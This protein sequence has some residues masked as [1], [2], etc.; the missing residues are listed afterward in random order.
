MKVAPA[1]NVLLDTRPQIFVRSIHLSHGDR[2]PLLHVACRARGA[3]LGCSP[4]GPQHE[5]P[6]T[7]ERLLVR[8]ATDWRPPETAQGHSRQRRQRP[9]AR[10]RSRAQRHRNEARHR[11]PGKQ[12][13]EGLCERFLATSDRRSAQN[14]DAPATIAG[15]PNLLVSRSVRTCSAGTD[16]NNTR[17]VA[18]A[19][20]PDGMRGDTSP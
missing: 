13:F 7:A 15:A 3:A 12:H 16:G 18:I 6:S 11:G 17:S 1:R 14:V 20:Q 4:C 19:F 10:Y 9:R 8:V 5:A 2:S